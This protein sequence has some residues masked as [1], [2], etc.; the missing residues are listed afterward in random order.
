MGP[1]CLHRRS[2]IHR[3][4][5]SKHTPYKIKDGVTYKNTLD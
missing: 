5:T 4:G 2:Y 1:S 3:G